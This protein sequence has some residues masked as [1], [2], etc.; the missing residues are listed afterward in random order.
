MASQ[1]KIR[2]GKPEETDNS[3]INPRGPGQPHC[4]PALVRGL[5][6]ATRNRADFE[7]AGN[8]IVDPF[9]PELRRT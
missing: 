3:P 1:G 9:A 4:R 2:R 8:E 5:V 7:N 6:I